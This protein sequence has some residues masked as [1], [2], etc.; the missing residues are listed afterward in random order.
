VANG[1]FGGYFDS[2]LLSNDAIFIGDFEPR[3]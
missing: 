1:N 3:G 2:I